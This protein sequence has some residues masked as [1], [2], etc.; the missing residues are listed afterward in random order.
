MEGVQAE[1]ERLEATRAEADK[2]AVV[3]VVA[4]GVGES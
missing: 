2:M 4:A 1:E 3:K